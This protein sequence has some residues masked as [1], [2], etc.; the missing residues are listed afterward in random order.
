MASERTCPH[1]QSDRLLLSGTKLREAL[2]EGA[3]IPAEFSR[4]EVLQVLRK[5]YSLEAARIPKSR[6]TLQ[7]TM[8]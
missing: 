6:R 8:L 3:D 4:P 2:F 5:H 1:P 7:G